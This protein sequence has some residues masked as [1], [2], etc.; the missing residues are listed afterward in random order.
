MASSIGSGDVLA[1]G[2]LTYV[3]TFSE[4][5]A[6]AELG[7]E[8]VTLAESITGTSYPAISLD[9]TEGSTVATIAFG[10]VPE[11][12]YT[13][14]LLTSAT[15]FRDR[16]GNLLDGSPSFPLPSGDGTPG[17][18]FVVPFS[19]DVATAPF[20]VPL[21]QKL[22]LGSL[23]YDL[24]V[25]GV[26]NGTGDMDAYTVEVDAG[27]QIT[28][29]VQPD[30]AATARLTLIAPDGSS[31]S[32]DA[33][34]AGEP[35]VLANV[36][37]GE[38]GS[39]RIE[40]LSLDA[41]SPYTVQLILNASAELEGAGG[42]TNNDMASAQNIDDSFISLGGDATRG[43]VVG[44]ADGVT[45]SAS[46]TQ[47]NPYWPNTLTF[48]FDGAQ[49]PSGPAVLTITVKAD[50]G[51][52]SE[53]LAFNA[54][55]SLAQNL[56]VSGG[57]DVERTLELPISQDVL[58]SLAADGTIT[59]TFVPS[60][61]VDNF[62]TN[63][64]LTLDLSYPLSGEPDV[65]AFT[66]A[67]GDIASLVV[68]GQG[69]GGADVALLGP[70]GTLLALG[71]SAGN[72]ADEAIEN[73]VVDQ[74]GTY[75]ARVRGDGAYNL[76]VTRNAD[77]RL[78]RQ[79]MPQTLS[80]AN[81]VLAYASGYS[82][83]VLNDAPAAYYRL[84][85][86]TGATAADLTGNGHDG[87]YV[88]PVVR[89]VEGVLVGETDPAV[90]FNGGSEV[91]TVPDDP[92]LR[93]TALT[94]EAWVRR[95]ANNP[96]FAT[97]VMK[98]SSGSW[99]DGYGLHYLTDGTINFFVNNR[100]SNKLAVPLPADTWTHV[101]GTFDGTRMNLYLDGLLRA[102][103][104]S[105]ALVHSTQPLRIGNGQG[106]YPWR[107]VIDE[108]AVYP[109]ALT[110]AQVQEHYR[111]GSQ[112]GGLDLYR[113]EATEGASLVVTTTTP[114]DDTGEPV[115][116]DLDLRL[117]LVNPL[118]F[119]VAQDDNSANDGRNA[120]LT[121]A[122][123]GGGTGTY[124]L[125][126]L[127]D[128]AGDYVVHVAGGAPA[129]GDPPAVVLVSP[130]D[131]SVFADPPTALEFRFDQPLRLDSIAPEDLVLD[132]G[133]SSTSVEV[134]D[135]R[136]VRFVVSVPTTEAIYTYTLAA[137]GVEDLQ[138]EGNEEFS[139]TFSVD[140]TG[141]RVVAQAPALQ[142]SA[143]FSELTFEFDEAINPETFTLTDVNSFVGPG[144]VNLLGALSG[145][146]VSGN[147]ATVTF[148]AQSSI[149]TY[150]MN[151]GPDIEDNA[152]NAMDQ[153]GDGTPGEQ[154]DIYV[155]TVDLAS[156]DLRPEAV[157][158]PDGAQFGLPLDVSWTVRNIGTDP[159]LENW[160]DRIYLSQDTTL[161]TG[162][163]A[164]GTFPKPGGALNN[165]TT[166]SQS[167]PVTLPLQLSLVPGNYFILVQTDALG[168]QPESNETNNV[169]VSEVLPIE[170]PPLPDL[171][172]SDI[173]APLEAFSSQQIDISWT[174]TNQGTADASG[175]WND[176][177]F[178]SPDNVV[179]GNDVFYGSFEFAGTIPAGQSVVRTQRITL[180]RVISGD[181]WVV[182]RTDSGNKIF[183]HIRDDNNT[184]ID[185]VPIPITLSP[186][187][188]L[189]VSEITPPEEPFSGQQTLI[190]WVVTNTGTGST[191][192]ASW[193]DD[194]YLST[195]TVLGDD[196]VYLGRAINESY[197]N[198]GESY[199]SSL[200]VRLPRGIQGNYYFIVRTDI[201]NNVF[202][203]EDEDDN[204]RVAGPVNVQLT[205]PPDLQVT[206][207]IAPTQAFS[208]Q[209]MN[210]SWTIT[211]EGTGRTEE[212]AWV[213]GVYMS[214][215]EV[216]DGSDR[217]LGD[218]SHSGALDPDETYTRS[219]TVNLPIGV[220]GDF[221]FLVRTDRRNQVFEHVFES[222]NDGGDPGATTVN[223]T[224]PPDL[225]VE[226][227]DVP[228]TVR[229]GVPLPLTFQVT[230]FG[231]TAT[232]NSSWVD[233]IYL[234]P[235]ATWDPDSDV[236]LVDRTHAGALDIGE[237]YT[238]NLN[239]TL[240][241]GIEGPHHLIVVTDRPDAV[242]ELNNENNVGTHG[243]PMTVESR[244][245]D[246]TVSAFNAPATTEAGGF[247]LAEWTVINQGTGD[248]IVNSW[249]DRVI[250][251]VDA[252]LG[253]ADD[254]VLGTFS[255]SGVLAPGA[256]YTQVRSLP[257]PFQLVGSYN[258]FVVTDLNNQVYEGA[259]ETNNTT[260]SRPITVTRQVPDLQVTLLDIPSEAL[261]ATPITVTWTVE[262]L[263]SNTT[264]ATS[265]YDDIYLSRDAVIDGSDIQLK[266]ERRVNPLAPT[267]GYSRSAT[268]VLPLELSGDY[269]V[270]VRTDSTNVVLENPLEGNNDRASTGT[271]AIKRNDDPDPGS[272]A[273]LPVDLTVTSVDVPA[274]GIT[275]Q[276]I[277]VTWTVLNEVNPTGVRRWSDNIYLSRDQIF[278]RQTDTF[279]GYFDH[280]TGLGKDESYTKTRAVTIPRGLSGPFYVFVVTDATGR[281]AETNELNN[282]GYDPQ[283]IQVTLAPPADLVVGTITVPAN[284]VPGRNASITYTVNNQGDDPALGSWYDSV[285][286]S[287]DETW[288]INDAFF[289]R[290]RHVGNV[291]G[292]SSYTETLTAPLPGVLPGDY[293]V[294]V[295]SD[296]RN[297]IPESD[298][299]NNLGASLDQ[300]NIDAQ[301]LELDVPFTDN[302][303]TGQSA[304]FKIE[305]TGGT[306]V[307]IAFDTVSDNA[308]N[309]LYV[310]AG[311]MPTRGQ[312]DFSASQPFVSDQELIFPAEMT[313]T[314]Y[315]LAYSSSGPSAP[316][317]TIQAEVIP[318]S[319]RSATKQDIGNVGRFTAKVRGAE[320][321]DE[322]E[323]ELV[324]EEDEV[325]P[326]VAVFIEDSTVAYVTFDLTLARLGTYTLQARRGD[327]TVVLDEPMTL[328]QS[329][330]HDVLVTIQGAPSVR[331]DRLYSFQMFYGNDGG[332][333]TM[334]PLLYADSTTGIPIGLGPNALFS[335]APLHVLGASADGPLDI[336]RPG[337]VGSV[338][339]YFRSGS[340]AAGVGI[341]IRAITSD[342]SRVLSAEDWQEIEASIRPTTISNENWQPFWARL[343]SRIGTRW[344]D[345]VVFLNHLVKELT[346]PGQ[347]LH[348]VRGMIAAIYD[349]DPDYVPS[350]VATGQLLD[351]DTG[352]PLEDVELLAYR[353]LGGGATTLAG[354]VRTDAEGRFTLNYLLGGDYELA[355]GGDN[356]FDQNRDL[357]ADRSP[358]AFTLE[359]NQ[360]LEGLA[361][362]A[363]PPSDV[364]PP[365]KLE[366]PQILV[367]ST[368]VPHMFWLLN[369]RVWH[370]WNDGT[371]WVG[372]EEVP[373]AEARDFS[374][375][376]AANLI[377]G[378]QPGVAL[379]FQGDGGV[380][381]TNIL[382]S[383]G[384]WNQDGQW[385]WSLPV[386]ITED[387]IADSEPVVAV[388]Q[389]GEMIVVYLKENEQIQDDSDLYYNQVNVASSDL[390]MLQRV[391]DHL[392]LEAMQDFVT[393]VSSGSWSGGGERE[394][395]GPGF[396]KKYGKV[397]FR[398]L[399]EGGYTADCTLDVSA[400]IEG[401]LGVEIKLPGNTGA[402]NRSYYVSGSG[403]YD[404]KWQ[405]VGTKGNGRYELI[406]ASGSAKVS[407]AVDFNVPLEQAVSFLPPNLSLPG[408]IILGFLRKAKIFTADFGVRVKGNI[409]GNFSWT[410]TN[411]PP[412]AWVAPDSASLTAEVGADLYGK[413]S[414]GR[415]KARI[416]GG[417]S[418][419]TQL[420]PQFKFLGV[421]GSWGVTINIPPWFVLNYSSDETDIIG[422]GVDFVG[423]N[424][425]GL[426]PGVAVEFA[427]DPDASLGTG[428]TY[429]ADN[430]ASVLSNV[431]GDLYDDEDPSIVKGPNG[432]LLMSWTKDLGPGIGS[433]IV[434]S[435]FDGTSWSA[436]VEIPGSRGGAATPSL[437]FD[438]DDNPLVLWS[439]M[440]LSSL[441]PHS[442]VD[443]VL[444][445]LETTDL[446]FSKFDGSVWSVAAPA[447]A[448]LGTDESPQLAR[449]AEGTIIATWTNATDDLTQLLVS[450]WDGTGWSQ[451]EAIANGEILGRASVG[452]VNGGTTI[453]WSQDV[454][455]D[456]ELT[457]AVIFTSVFDD[458]WSAPQEFTYTL[459][460][461]LAAASAGLTFQAQGLLDGVAIS[462]PTPP[463]ECL[464][465]EEIKQK[466]QGTNEGCGSE[467]TFDEDTCTRT[468]TYKPCVVQPR[469]P[470]D[471]LGPE[472]FGDEHW[473]PAADTFLYTIRFE[474]AADATAPAQKVVVTQTLDPDLDPRTFRVGSFGFGDYIFDVPENRAFYNERLDFVDEFGFV[475]DVAFFIDPATG[476]ATWTLDTIDPAT[477]EPPV[478]A[479][480]GFLPTNDEEGRGEGFLQYTVRAKRL[481][482]TGSVVDAEAR[483]VFDTEGPI[484]T[485]PIF[486]TLDA[487]R[488][489]SQVDTLPSAVD[490]A[491]FT[492]T[493]SGVD[494]DGGS[495][496]GGYTIYVSENGGDFTAWLS[497]TPLTEAVY[498][499]VEGNTYA[500]YS[501][502][503][504]NAGNLE[505]V[506]ISADTTTT[507]PGTKGIR[508]TPTAGLE[509]TED[510][511]TASF[512]VVLT[513]APTAPVTVPIVSRDT[514]E[515]VPTVAELVFTPD[516]WSTP[517]QVTVVGRDDLVDDGDVVYVIT[518]G[519]LS[520][521]DADYD[522]L[523]ADPV[524][525]TNVDNDT[526]AIVVSPTTG[527]VTSETGDAAQFTVVLATQPAA[528]VTIAV[529]TRDRSE[530]TVSPAR[531]IFTADNWDVP[532]TVVV[533]GA[534]DDQQDGDVVYTVE[535]GPVTGDDV[536]YA[537]IDPDDV[538]LT[539]LDNDTRGVSVTPSSGLQ[540]T[541]AGGQAT[542]QVV[543]NTAPLFDVTIPVRSSD[544]SEGT[545]SI[546]ELVF[547]PDNW[548]VPQTVTVTGVNDDIDDGNTAYLVIL[549]PIVSDD[550]VYGGVNPRDANVVNLDDDTAGIV[551]FPVAGLVTTEG[552]GSDEF[553][554][555]LNSEP[556]ADVRIPVVS[557]NIAEG[558]VDV[559]ELV[560]TADN[561]D[562]PQKVTVTGENDDDRDGD[563]VY[564][565]EFG[566]VASTDT[567]YAA[568]MV[569]K[570]EVT[571]QDNDSSGIV[572]TPTTGL[573]T[574]EA[575][576]TASFTVVLSVLPL[577]NVTIAVRSSNENEGT[578]SVD[579]LVFTPQN[580]DQ[581]QTVVV[582][583]VQ[584][585]IDDG[586]VSYQV[587]LD[588]AVSGDPMY[589]GVDPRD[590]AVTNL[591]DDT[592]GITVSPVIGLETTEAGGTA[593]FTVVLTSQPLADVRV[594]LESNDLS[595][596]SIAVAEL[597]FTPENWS[598]PQ[599]VTV[600]GVD[601]LDADGDV[602]YRILVKAALSDDPKYAGIDANDVN[603]VNV[604]ND[605]L[606]KIV[607]VTVQDGMTQRSYVDLL[608]IRFNN[609][610]NLADLISSGQIAS[611]VSL[612]NLGVN[613]DADADQIVS[614]SAS[615]FRLAVDPDTG[616]AVLTWSL[617]SFA[618]TKSTLADGY[619]RLRVHGDLI[620]DGRGLAADGDRDGDAGGDFV[621][622]FHRLQGDVD[623]DLDNDT[624]DMNIVNAALGGRPGR[625]NWN[626]D[627][628]LDRD[629]LVSTRDR[630]LVARAPNKLIVP[631]TDVGDTAAEADPRTLN[632]TGGTV[633]T[634]SSEVE[635]S[636]YDGDVD[637]FRFNAP[638]SG[639]LTIGIESLSDDVP[640]GDL[641][642][643]VYESAA[644]GAPLRL[645]GRATGGQVTTT[646]V[647]GRRYFVKVD[648]ADG[649]TVSW[650]DYRVTMAL[651]EFDAYLPLAGVDVAHADYGYRGQGY[652]VAIIDTGIDYTH[653][654]LAGRVIL[655]PDFGDYDNDPID[656]VGH[657]THVAGIVASGNRYVPGVAPDADLIALKITPDGSFTASVGAIVQALQWV[658]DYREVY[659]IVAV[660]ISFGG[661]NVAKGTTLAA[662]EPLYRALHDAGVFIAVASGNSYAATGS[663]E[664]LNVL[665]ASYSV[666]AVGA[667][668]DS[669]VGSVAFANG[670]ADYSTGPDRITSFTQRSA[671]LDLMAPGGDILNLARDGGVT[672]RNGTS[673]AAPFAAG[674]AVLV[675]E[676][677]DRMGLHVT[678]GQ[679]LE[680]LR[681][682]G[683]SVFDGDDE[684]DNVV[685]S[686]RAYRRIDVAGA[687]RSLLASLPDQ[688]GAASNNGDGGN[689]VGHLDITAQ[690]AVDDLFAGIAGGMPVVGDLR[691]ALD[692]DTCGGYCGEAAARRGLDVRPFLAS[693]KA[694]ELGPAWIALDDSVERLLAES[695][696]DQR[697]R[698]HDDTEGLAPHDDV[699]A[700][701]DTLFDEEGDVLLDP[702][703]AFSFRIRNDW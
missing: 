74:A 144:G 449:T 56:F 349:R 357:S 354:T 113:F 218:F 69:D 192:A 408:T 3:V 623:G 79:G 314:Y 228:S 466:T 352:V 663:R 494:D 224:P 239:V 443:E 665:A 508:V 497:D 167:V 622:H 674:A 330:G 359:N 646:A 225:E 257:V 109:T 158:V 462:M 99:T 291:P 46:Q 142:A 398:M 487:G 321:T 154:A 383:V 432:E 251:S 50:L 26:L 274:T 587:I 243:T 116:D 267:E 13:L 175:V 387:D 413:A 403:K 236:K 155:G 546:D 409:G 365:Q 690:I 627:A 379:T 399:F 478:D 522:G 513:A 111:A 272:G 675:R 615:Q 484:D 467:V 438:S 667:V 608:A 284:G 306:T 229:A 238:V 287:A 578:V 642:I 505:L 29:V 362:Y 168:T 511:G 15:A 80:S 543:L 590:V 541:E 27:Q 483:I 612:V 126:V 133:A 107:G 643:T 517:Q 123:P 253:N 442:T 266:R 217:F 235:D 364:T 422:S 567:V 456:S 561:W 417:V 437:I 433:A 152:G 535:V 491:S 98:T 360:D 88:G 426:P 498:P 404:G 299:T 368:G 654:D 128:R 148:T 296:I 10:A 374:V 53:Y 418:V 372:A 564:Y 124:L 220:S 686:Q 108:V 657:G 605:G 207:V 293:R 523:E 542:F 258:L 380:N 617:D 502:A 70:A 336:L 367:D 275:G 66:L 581:P 518:V 174:L 607:D 527:L 339:I 49:Q 230:N 244:P 177:V 573:E 28:L 645:E 319:L 685:N 662:V 146:T 504:D 388:D 381:G 245:A 361:L 11:G 477:G 458:S 632:A 233:S 377:D 14:T 345:Y 673:M 395:G 370:A 328:E 534:D 603:L 454:D 459:L 219:A 566:P 579:Q 44:F 375:D 613:A 538:S 451:A 333:D 584:D 568:L 4:P 248:T 353:L 294:I 5:L 697:R 118:G 83:T 602:A 180:P 165:G 659:N 231:A 65:Y 278:D 285:Y 628:D 461:P 338:P 215:D 35:V 501:V 637:W 519:P 625:A 161:G 530:G 683:V 208:G 441:T 392:D 147:R 616:E 25:G 470:N 129:A 650:A 416:N 606:T 67:E 43:A 85:E 157:T 571:N 434:V 629:N 668:W 19:V 474:N 24:F 512:S 457:E 525:V 78:P 172:V 164:L 641:R 373:G 216:I 184:T 282:T 96:Q 209:P 51:A 280:T 189:Q 256:S 547:T 7:V 178:L 304:F 599:S 394:L 260:A 262:N 21:E 47:T 539:N 12:N 633:R 8:D 444:G 455:P 312:F 255:R 660:N 681:S 193:Y 201:Y 89:G 653:P 679:I 396:L 120:R 106:N 572:V 486:N 145:V 73:F 82:G 171:V 611:A 30:A 536:V 450:T 197:L 520:S 281:I 6:V 250:I 701:L 297:F 17:D 490:S 485:P 61:S 97:V 481:A 81:T 503:R 84:N 421:S 340:V 71:T 415:F 252:T 661:G 619:Y 596:G 141:P 692:L 92:A 509:T 671:G 371:G 424:E 556:T 273:A 40:V 580:W 495:G 131:G 644:D 597:V 42:P 647:A 347:P 309:E 397:T 435:E 182:V 112:G 234:S 227:V 609:A 480:L 537:S 499:G 576:G 62:G 303:G 125:R 489:Q 198:A 38:T 468:I 430:N 355:I 677:A 366:R 136:T 378:S 405:A 595:E 460:A 524:L 130:G 48:N 20:P 326:A 160:S 553:T 105:P 649:R 493:W 159:A 140:R 110:L 76:V 703:S 427:Y 127:S 351:S 475:V 188:N 308:F 103:K 610:A 135:A 173:A 655:G 214:E 41:A 94:L 2:D 203:F 33:T 186:F 261:S 515:G 678:A 163:I 332:N 90:R 548:N 363:I 631:S 452:I 100:N 521:N 91:V 311:A 479:S 618:G 31:S 301:L 626:P 313:G 445:V 651:D 271:I 411:A 202:E 149:G 531:L 506:P 382:Y 385:E 59:F 36:A 179:G 211:N 670:A 577:A 565:V 191:S 199:T 689:Y 676:A 680:I 277:D 439:S 549:D 551:V 276:P 117:E 341:Q 410:G 45:Y 453:F 114:G 344:G 469:D 247:L 669:N 194:V 514:S 342:D 593:D 139:G 406:S 656:T 1:P 9:Y 600:T 37:A 436:P 620:V 307:R 550:A 528:D 137:D 559:S 72:E 268:V 369:G 634:W 510:G 431:A 102:S 104:D 465:C 666:A 63:H 254:T 391:L 242:F 463:D 583:G 54:E 246:L 181:W 448:A 265:W 318:F 87:T 300:V 183:E 122:V 699:F 279:L 640:T 316:E 604:D 401:R 687:I 298:E 241:N 334:A 23:V 563:V 68:A 150:T 688:G 22:P 428:N 204:S 400:A 636:L 412:F 331:P 492:V 545:I 121:Y 552:G 115:N 574:T 473:V 639:T 93:P 652:S 488:P 447:Y 60:S 223:L 200:P 195:D 393:Q 196:D 356:F 346:T 588:P 221:F 420:L 263:G 226:F 283:A 206:S 569:P 34:G 446:Y 638:A 270:I 210:L 302:L 532:Q 419:E 464:K 286:I 269:Y 496:I 684:H 526:A 562:V 624:D 540:T 343:Q 295:R 305:L 86:L 264:N 693:Q 594:P 700:E 101:V 329:I 18:D 582:T 75:Y 190:E 132:N 414:A 702:R 601:D 39:Y 290:I 585:Q 429:F 555:V 322:T 350:Y 57:E 95:D 614:L 77:F 389:D 55:G 162:D 237:S 592:A 500:F 529:T 249:N 386:N 213:D 240:P 212:S 52:S 440:D 694:R 407:G 138:G 348:D 119:L 327:S 323:F 289:G 586:D 325:Y 232:P 635:S 292:G 589:Q 320:F 205:P 664:G 507:V 672:T 335:N 423:L 170:L 288:D 648:A 557:S 358:P 658:I 621:R 402:S 696:L 682:G 570:V 695:R 390:I 259:N 630:L 64:Y 591:D 575:G 376:A 222:N 554:V 151:I 134:V 516:N 153:D 143:P 384:Q 558:T 58:E 691:S 32:I 187:P 166:Y 169:A 425:D 337:S 156:P 544:T 698:V 476:I 598:V 16:R 533:T 560:F 315:I 324:G 310:R 185:N 482:A 317:Y 471:I 176:Q 472:G